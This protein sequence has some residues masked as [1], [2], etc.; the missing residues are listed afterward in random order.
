MR[1]PDHIPALADHALIADGWRGALVGPTGE[2][3]WLCFPLWHD[4]AVF[5]RLIGSNVSFTVRPRGRFTHAGHYED[6][7]L[8]WHARWVTES[9]TVECRDAL[10][11]PAGPRR[12][13]LLRQIVGV[14][15]QVTVDVSLDV[16]FDYERAR[17]GKWRK[18]VA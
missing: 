10:A 6:G 16:R 3:T 11:L 15:G 4:P 7:T 1:T 5:G 13:V 9:G 18:E 8:V 17:I 14:A 12:A 2:Q